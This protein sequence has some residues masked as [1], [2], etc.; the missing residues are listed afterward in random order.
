MAE[1]QKTLTPAQFLGCCN[2]PLPYSHLMDL[3]SHRSSWLLSNQSLLH[4]PVAFYVPLP[5]RG[6]PPTLLFPG[7]QIQACLGLVPPAG[8][9]PW[10]T[11][12]P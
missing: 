11:P 8:P 5:H 3:T 9:R 10:Q 4:T 12:R 2:V 6:F 1:P 7:L